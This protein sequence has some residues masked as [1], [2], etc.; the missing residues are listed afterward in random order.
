MSSTNT[1]KDSGICSVCDRVCKLLLKNGTVHKHGFGANS[2][3][4]AGSYLP[5]RPNSTSNPSQYTQNM[6]RVATTTRSRF[7]QSTQ[8]LTASQSNSSQNPPII[9]DHPFDHPEL[10]KPLIKIIPKSSR[11]P[12]GQILSSILRDI[13]SDPSH[14]QRWNDLLRFGS[15]LLTKPARGGKHHNLSNLIAKQTAAYIDP[16][17]NHGSNRIAPIRPSKQD[18]A[19][20]ENLLAAAVTSKLED[21]NLRA[22]IHL[23]CSDDA[24]APHNIETLNALSHKHPQA[25]HDRVFP[26]RPNDAVAFQVSENDVRDVMRSFPAGSSG[27]PDGI[28]P[29]HLLDL[30]SGPHVADGLLPSLTAFINLL[31]RGDIPE[32]VKPVILGGD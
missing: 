6:S 4:C 5:P 26:S 1:Q 28:T 17:A 18:K 22:A 29:R 13:V 30:S 10:H 14:I 20:T 15:E 16:N 19:S 24:V 9:C 27:G 8:A 21:G 2:Q 7:S 3:A 25:P 12:C 23:L 32:I 11:V 31:L